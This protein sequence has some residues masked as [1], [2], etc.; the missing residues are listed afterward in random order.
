MWI[1]LWDKSIKQLT[2]SGPGSRALAP[3]LWRYLNGTSHFLVT[4]PSLIWISKSSGFCK[5]HYFLPINIIKTEYVSFICVV[6]WSTLCCT[7]QMPH[8]MYGASLHIKMSV[9]LCGHLYRFGQMN[10]CQNLSS[11][12]IFK[13][14][15]STS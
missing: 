13:P 5:V 6:L 14:F 1:P 12:S 15:S 8:T 4:F 9:C 10:L 7:F 2:T 11:V 3:G